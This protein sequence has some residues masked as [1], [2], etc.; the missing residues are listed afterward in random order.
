[1]ASTPTPSTA[2]S[3]EN[4]R[5]VAR[6][7]ERE[8]LRTSRFDSVTSLFMALIIFIGTFVSM[9]FIIW[10][11]SRWSFPPLAIE[12]II[13]NPAGRGE[14]PEGFER[15]FEPPGA[16]EVEELME[17]TLQDTLEAVTDAVSSVAGALATTDTAATAT[18]SGT[19]AGDSRPPGPPGEGEDIIPRFE[20][21]QLNFTAR[22]V[23]SYATQLDYFKIELGAIGGSI[24]GVDIASNLSSRVQKSRIQDTA[25]EKRL[26][27]MWNSPSPLMEFD[28]QLLSS[29]S[30]E[31]A[32]RQML[33][34]IPKE[35]ENQ[36]A[37]IELEYS[38]S[39]GHPSVTEIAKTVFEC[40]SNGGDYAFEVVSQRYRKSRK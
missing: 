12:P 16:E 31:L 33:K 35:L 37:V 34:F 17:P 9:L 32:N 39:K 2:T 11:T 40:K 24:Q 29:A 4:P 5:V 8:K 26:Y 27:F 13:E 10:L 19:G 28:R 38:T 25:S 14:N 30:I 23:R 18:T 6:L 7:R 15:D 36:L 21:W 3:I 20:R 22:D 1:M